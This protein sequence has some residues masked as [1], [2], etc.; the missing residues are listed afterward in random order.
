MSLIHQNSAVD[1]QG[2]KSSVRKCLGLGKCYSNML[3]SQIQFLFY[4]PGGEREKEKKKKKIFALSWL[5]SN[6]GNCKGKWTPFPSSVQQHRGKLPRNANHFGTAFAEMRVLLQGSLYQIEL[7]GISKTKFKIPRTHAIAAPG[8]VQELQCSLI[9][10]L[11]PPA[12]H[13]H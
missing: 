11:Y 4:T 13:Q 7:C 2:E 3:F 10:L 5:V 1:L 9:T 8:T 6:V 12:R